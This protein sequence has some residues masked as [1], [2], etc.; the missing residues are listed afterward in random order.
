[1][2]W[3]APEARERISDLPELQ[4]IPAGI[5][6]F[7]P[8]GVSEGQVAFFI[9]EERALV[10]AEFF[11]GTPT[12]LQLCPSPATGDIEEFA[13]SMNELRQLP[14]ERVLVAHGSPVLSAGADAITAA[15]ESFARDHRA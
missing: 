2:V 15:L 11:L 14:I 12:G 10:V 3:I 6:I 5:E 1:M 7:T 4:T 9:E 8:C 13:E